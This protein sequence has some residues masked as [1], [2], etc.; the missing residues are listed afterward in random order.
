MDT[1]VN[2]LD[3]NLPASNN[4]DFTYPVLFS[5]IGVQHPIRGVDAEDSQGW[6]EAMSN[7]IEYFGLPGDRYTTRFDSNNIVFLFHKE[8]DAALCILK[9][10]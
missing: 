7:I 10:K 3:N 4:K 8:Q 1:S 2:M 9:F 6:A 5:L